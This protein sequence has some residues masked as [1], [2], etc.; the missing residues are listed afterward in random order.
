MAMIAN[1]IVKLEADDKGRLPDRLSRRHPSRESPRAR[2][3][4]LDPFGE[5]ESSRST[6]RSGQ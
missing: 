6:I 2:R 3:S 1:L 4:S 5:T